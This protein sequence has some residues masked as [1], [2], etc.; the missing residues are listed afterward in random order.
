MVLMTVRDNRRGTDAR[1]NDAVPQ[2]NIKSNRIGDGVVSKS[3]H[4]PSFLSISIPIH[5]SQTFK[6]FTATY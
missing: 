3:P 2:G 1:S 6:T 4:L 5:I